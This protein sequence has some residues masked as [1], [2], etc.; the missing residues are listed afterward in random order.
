LFKEAE[1]EQTQKLFRQARVLKG[2][3]GAIAVLVF[4]LVIVWAIMFFKA[5]ARLR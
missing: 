3:A 5:Q 4:V 2:I 1:K